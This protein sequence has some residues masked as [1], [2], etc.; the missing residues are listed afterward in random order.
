MKRK[1]ANARAQK[2]WQKKLK[3]LRNLGIAR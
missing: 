1:K 3:E 2:R